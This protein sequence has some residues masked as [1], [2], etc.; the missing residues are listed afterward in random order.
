MVNT[1]DAGRIASAISPT[2]RQIKPRAGVKQG[3]D[4]QAWYRPSS[5]RQFRSQLGFLSCAC[6]CMSASKAVLLGVDWHPSKVTGT[7]PLTSKPMP[8]PK[9]QEGKEHRIHAR[10]SDCQA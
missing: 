4:L 9:A 10:P 3:L 2:V 5:A 6:C 8:I 7:A 1:K